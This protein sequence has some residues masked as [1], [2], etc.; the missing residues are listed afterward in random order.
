MEIGAIIILPLIVLALSA[1]EL[2]DRAKR[3]QSY[4]RELECTV[5]RQ[6]R[7]LKHYRFMRLQKEMTAGERH[8]TVKE[9]KMSKDIITLGK[10]N[11]ND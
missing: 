9:Q 3:H 4:I 10:G 2:W 1:S 5:E 8:R 7:S 6:E 11:V